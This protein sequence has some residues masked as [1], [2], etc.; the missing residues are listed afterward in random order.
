MKSALFKNDDTE[1]E[2]QIILTNYR[3][4]FLLK[5]NEFLISEEFFSIPILSIVK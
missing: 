3:I 1:L 4:T 5:N 2:G